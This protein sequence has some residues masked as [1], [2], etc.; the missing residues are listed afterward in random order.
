M[1]KTI[2][3]TNSYKSNTRVCL[4]A[5]AILFFLLK[6]QEDLIWY[7][8]F[9]ALLLCIMLTIKIAYEIIKL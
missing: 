1:R 7:K 9:T 2:T 3:F 5:Q 8:K 4:V 6:A